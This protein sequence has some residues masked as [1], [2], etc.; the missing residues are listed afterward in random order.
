MMIYSINELEGNLVRDSR[1]EQGKKIQK[2]EM[3]D[4][5]DKE[6]KGSRQA[7]FKTVCFVRN[8]R[9]VPFFRMFFCGVKVGDLMTSVSN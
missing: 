5:G 4:G 8:T 7:S 9:R 1:F 2:R 3:F 6:R